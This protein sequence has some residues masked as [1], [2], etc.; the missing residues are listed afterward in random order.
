MTEPL[1]YLAL[2]DSYTTCTGAS[3]PEHRWPTIVSLRLGAALS[4]EVVVTNL[5]V[6]GYTTRDLIRDELPHLGD[7]AWELITVLIGV[8][9]FVQ[10]ST[11]PAYR[12]R[13]REIYDRLSAV[14]GA[15]VV[16]ISVPDF[17]F[18]PTA[19]LYASPD[20]IR[21]GLQAFNAVARDEAAAH[22]FQFVDLF[23]VSRSRIGEPDWI[24]L[25]GLHPGDAQYAAW[26]DHI[27]SRLG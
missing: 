10:G 5:G 27:W 9:D 17:S 18:A 2:G 16:A 4:R 25:D 19:D 12:Q 26:A 22:G 7:G 21:S 24:G 20:A 15:R 23:D 6:N 1:H 11:G 14:A 8:N 3:S 13:L